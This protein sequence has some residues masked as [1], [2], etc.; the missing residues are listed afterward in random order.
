[1]NSTVEDVDGR[2]LRRTQN[3]E[4][5]LDALA[6]LFREGIY[7]PSTNEIAERAGL[8]PRSLFRYFDDVDDLNRA[9]IERRLERALPLVEVGVTADAPTLT[10]I[11]HLAESRARL[12]E[13]IAP[14]A[15]AG[16][17]CAHR[18]AI[19]A[20]R[21]HETRDEL[22][23]Q[24]RALFAPE[25]QGDRAALLPAIDA[26]CSFEAYELLRYDQGL[27][28]AKT[29]SALIAALTTLLDHT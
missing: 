3:R 1:M 7:Q 22:R 23:G 11:E 2:R 27:S 4:A 21:I 19:V 16:R 12:F 6:A 28:R 14:E 13:A 10:K 5:V 24:I 15:R 17:I 18:H 9:A 20:E 26:L 25:L 29:T 8:S